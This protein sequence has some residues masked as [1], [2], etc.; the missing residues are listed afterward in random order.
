[1]ACGR[2]FLGLEKWFL[3]QTLNL[4]PSRRGLG[5]RCVTIPFRDPRG[6]SWSSVVLLSSWRCVISQRIAGSSGE[7][8]RSTFIPIVEKGNFSLQDIFKCFSY[9]SP[10]TIFF[11]A[12]FSLQFF[13]WKL[14]HPPPPSKKMIVRLLSLKFIVVTEVRPA[15]K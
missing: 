9:A 11:S 14:P 8:N 2:S 6:I 7:E 10:Y 4:G 12:V 1:M 15:R 3:S 13:F 5:E